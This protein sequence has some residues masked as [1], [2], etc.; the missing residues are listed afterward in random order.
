MSDTK[1]WAKTL[2][3]AEAERR[4]LQPFAEANGVTIDDGYAIQ[5]EVVA[6]KV[7]AGD[8]VIGAKLGLTSKAK[9]IAMNVNEPGYGQVLA[10]TL[11]P[12]EEP[13]RVAD[14]IHPRAEPEIV[15]SM[16][17]S[18]A[19]PGVTARDV[20]EATDAVGCGLEIIDSRFAAFKFTLADV[21]ADNTSAAKFVLGGTWVSPRDI[22][23]LSLIGCVLDVNGENVAT[24]SGAAVMGHPAESV[25]LL[26]NWLGRRGR[27]IE[28]GWL[29]LSGGLTNAV[30]LSPGTYVEASFGRV[31]HVS[32]RAV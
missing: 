4:E 14:L 3:D 2:F 31:G 16:G 9:Q 20:L 29:V 32:L 18:I 22:P 8:R 15:F 26:A 30:P 12:L 25:A 11:L 23:D 6:M 24:A 17:R 7:A 13:L 27:R 21:V 10:S 28:A 5:D 1:H 19:G